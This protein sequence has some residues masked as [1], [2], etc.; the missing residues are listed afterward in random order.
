MK[1][2]Q[3]RLK[4]RSRLQTER[5]FMNLKGL[6]EDDYMALINFLVCFRDFNCLSNLSGDALQSM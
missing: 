6:V 5:T 3:S 2:C 1:E 4:T